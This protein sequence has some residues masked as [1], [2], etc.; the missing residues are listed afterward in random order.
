M[1]SH[2]FSYFFASLVGGPLHALQ[3]TPT[4][5]PLDAC[6]HPQIHRVRPQQ[7]RLF[8]S[9]QTLKRLR[10]LQLAHRNQRRHH[11]SQQQAV[12]AKP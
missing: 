12:Q 11:L 7:T 6:S 5:C 1:S 2:V 8:P 9:Q 3:K 4:L 10:L